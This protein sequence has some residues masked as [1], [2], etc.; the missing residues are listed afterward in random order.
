M[1]K[2]T[3][4]LLRQAYPLYRPVLS[5]LGLLE[6]IARKHGSDKLG[7]GY[8]KHYKRHFKS[9][10]HT[11]RKL[12]EVGVG[13]GASLRTWKDYFPK[14]E[15]FGLDIADRR[16]HEEDRIKIFQGDQNDPAVLAEIAARWGPFDIIIDD[17]SH[18]SEHIITTYFSLFP[19]L[20]A[21]G[22]YVIEDLYLSYD[23]SVGGSSV[24]FDSPKTAF[25]MIKTLIDDMHYQ[26]IRARKPQSY[27]DQITEISIYPKICFIQ[28][29]DNSTRDEYIKPWYTGAKPD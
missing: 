10:R 14:A 22:L 4:R 23:E 24:V 29:G 18:V 3:K 15:I 20:K 27:G 7:H 12:L 9:L 25:G 21:N 28:K 5:S 16:S 11:T 13:A 1:Q 2:T 17:G 26:Y 6:Y 19:R 8:L